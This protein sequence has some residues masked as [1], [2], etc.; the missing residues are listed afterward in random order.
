MRD[1][2]TV[3]WTSRNLRDFPACESHARPEFARKIARFFAGIPA[4]EA[5]LGISVDLLAR[6]KYNVVTQTKN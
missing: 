4:A 1:F 2:P 6:K 3:A 5:F